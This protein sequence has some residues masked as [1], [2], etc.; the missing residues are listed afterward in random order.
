MSFSLPPSN[1][2]RFPLA[3]RPRDAARA[4]N[5][6]ERSLWQLARDGGV[7]CVRVGRSVLYPV[8]A[9]QKWLDDSQKGG[10]Q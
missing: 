6:S 3:L 9:L 7:P 2:G 8:A 10:G 4:L 1:D 5:I